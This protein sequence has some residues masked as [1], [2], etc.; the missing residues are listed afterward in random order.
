[1]FDFNVASQFRAFQTPG[2]T[3][4]SL[5]IGLLLSY[6]I[7]IVEAKEPREIAIEVLPSVVLLVMADANNNP[8]AQG[9]GFV[10][11]PGVLA[12]NY[13]VIQKAHYGVAKTSNREELYKV[14]GVIAADPDLDL[15]LL[16]VPTL[17]ARPLRLAALESVSVGDIVYAIGNPRGLEGTF[18]NGIISAVRKTEKENFIQ[19]TAPISPGSS[20]GP[21]VNSNGEVIGVATLTSK[22]GQ[23]LNFA[24][25]SAHLAR[26]LETNEP[27]QSLESAAED[28]QSDEPEPGTAHPQ[29]EA[30]SSGFEITHVTLPKPCYQQ[31]LSFSVV[32]RN[33]RAVQLLQVDTVLYD[34]EGT[35]VDIVPSFAFQKLDPGSATRFRSIVPLDVCSLA[36]LDTDS[37]RLKFKV[38]NFFFTN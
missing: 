19:I 7:T 28:S 20:G 13:H 1:M 31:K 16:S 6:R 29:E 9:S 4:L 14:E 38:V 25:S 8:I 27:P 36:G 12:T 17:E 5:L 32:N 21:V 22:V 15:A 3:V 30:D 26:M 23:N 35:Q 33:D 37:P 18:S 10:V 2:V 34:R 24:V 11:G